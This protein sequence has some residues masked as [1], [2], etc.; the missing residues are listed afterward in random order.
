MISSAGA[1]II[2]IKVMATLIHWMLNTREQGDRISTTSNVS[3]K[4][5]ECN[6]ED[7]YI[8][9]QCQTACVFEGPSL[10]AC[11]ET[12]ISAHRRGT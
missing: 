6:D 4:C 10:P 12:H 1:M 2:K 7:Y 5:M 3:R 8:T 9:E 11:S